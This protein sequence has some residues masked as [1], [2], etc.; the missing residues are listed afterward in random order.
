MLDLL[1]QIFQ[2]LMVKADRSRVAVN[3]EEEYC[4]LSH[5]E[6]IKVLSD[7]RDRLTKVVDRRHLTYYGS[8]RQNVIAIRIQSH[9][10]SNRYD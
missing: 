7:C 2:Y 8:K 5:I 6:E 9:H 4:S 10:W 1:T 3:R